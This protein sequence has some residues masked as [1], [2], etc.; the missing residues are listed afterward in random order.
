M[1]ELFRAAQATLE[2][3]ALVTGKILVVI[4]VVSGVFLWLKLRKTPHGIFTSFSAF[5]RMGKDGIGTLCALAVSLGGTIGA[6]N[7]IGVSGAV[8][9]G[10]RGAV[11]WLVV[12][13]FLGMTLK[14]AEVSLAMKHRKRL[15]D[16]SF[17][18]GAMYVC[19]QEDG[20]KGTLRGKLFCIFCILCAFVMGNVTQSCAIFDAAGVDGKGVGGLICAFALCALIAASLLGKAEA[21]FSFSS[22]LVPLMGILYIGSAAVVVLANCDRISGVIVDVLKGAF[23]PSDGDF[24]SL[25]VPM[26]YGF[27]RGLLSNEA[28]L[29]SSPIAHASADGAG[30]DSAH[31]GVVEVFFSTVVVGI[32][33][34]FALMC[35]DVDKTSGMYAENL[36]GMAFSEV[37]GGFGGLVVRLSTVLFAFTSIATWFFYSSV[38]AEF[39]WGENSRITKVVNALFCV[40]P[41]VGLVLT[42]ETATTLSD[43]ACFLMCAANLSIVVPGYFRS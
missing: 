31:M 37:L 20:A 36:A 27:S 42:V 28:G 7:I 15:D 38:S 5:G 29:G 26:A 13:A 30:N 21:V 2:K 9:L 12:G 1:N 8:L 35:T 25:F 34:S 43:I 23:V 14:F 6:G 39:L 33:T 11:L 16:G 22:V 41:L 10:G 32:L 4:I 40:A 17:R 3:T 18:G 19:S 24:K